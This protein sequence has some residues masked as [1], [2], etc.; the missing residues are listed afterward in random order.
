MHQ[1]RHQVIMISERRKCL[2]VG[3]HDRVGAICTIIMIICFGLFL[4]FSSLTRSLSLIPVSIPSHV[5]DREFSRIFYC[6]LQS[7]PASSCLV[8]IDSAAAIGL[9]LLSVTPKG[10]IWGLVSRWGVFFRPQASLHLRIRSPCVRAHPILFP[11][12]I[13]IRDNVAEA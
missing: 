1:A 12:Q 6:S 9:T 8:S 3:A 10:S 4:L 7:P 13:N 5:A 11:K 2:A